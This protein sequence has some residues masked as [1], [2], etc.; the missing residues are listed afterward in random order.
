MDTNIFRRLFEDKQSPTLLL[1][2]V[3]DKSIW[4]F[5][6]RLMNKNL[7]NLEFNDKEVTFHINSLTSRLINVLQVLNVDPNQYYEITGLDGY[8]LKSAIQVKD[9]WTR[10]EII[11]ILSLIQNIIRYNRQGK[12]DLDLGFISIITKISDNNQKQIHKYNELARIVLKDWRF[13]PQQKKDK[14]DN[15]INEY[16]Q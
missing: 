2:N 3:E 4:D 14:I 5:T 15:L 16:K 8:L 10:E 9:L 12:L 7:S 6:N 1:N 13:T 11:E